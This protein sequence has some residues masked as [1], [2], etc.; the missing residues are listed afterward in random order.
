MMAE[1]TGIPS[2]PAGAPKEIVGWMGAVRSRL[3]ALTSSPFTDSEVTRLRALLRTGTTTTTSTTV[4]GGPVFLAPYQFYS[5]S[6]VAWTSKSAVD[7]GVPAGAS[8][9]IID[10]YW[11]W[12]GKHDAHSFALIRSDTTKGNTGNPE[13]E[14][15]VALHGFLG[16]DSNVDGSGGSQQGVFP[17][18]EDGTF[19]FAVVETMSVWLRIV[20]YYPGSST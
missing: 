7:A 19:D 18:R 6:A 10:G 5:G 9:V 20:G 13:S 11:G 12:A 14:T 3:L 16:R 4:S 17:L 8:A 1:P 15:Y 2:T